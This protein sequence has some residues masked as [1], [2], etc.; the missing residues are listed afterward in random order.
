[1]HCLFLPVGVSERA[2][3]ARQDGGQGG[4]Q[5]EEYGAENYIQTIG[6]QGSKAATQSREN[7]CGCKLL[8][9]NRKFRPAAEIV[10]L[11]NCNSDLCVAVSMS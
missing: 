7:H 11:V 10:F 2:W 3:P 6:P 5:E 8:V 9:E 4:N 1:M